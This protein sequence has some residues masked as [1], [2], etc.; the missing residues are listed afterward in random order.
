MP[1]KIG[2]SYGGYALARKKN[3]RNIRFGAYL[4]CDTFK[5]TG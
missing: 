4:D 1:S 3:K 2:I 5:K